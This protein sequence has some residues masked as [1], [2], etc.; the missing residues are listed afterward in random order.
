MARIPTS[1]PCMLLSYSPLPSSIRRAKYLLLSDTFSTAGGPSFLTGATAKIFPVSG[2]MSLMATLPPLVTTFS[3]PTQTCSFQ[4]EALQRGCWNG[5]TAR[6]V[7]S[8]LTSRGGGSG[9]F[10]FQEA[11]M[12]EHAMRNGPSLCAHLPTCVCQHPIPSRISLVPC[13]TG[14]GGNLVHKHLWQ[15]G[16]DKFL[17]ISHSMVCLSRRNGVMWWRQGLN[18]VSSTV[19][20]S[21]PVCV[22]WCYYKV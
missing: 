7:K 12:R 6:R 11:F 19:T 16:L 10:S 22:C 5:Q 21:R 4:S 13:C 18:A 2:A 14:F 1:A 3:L 17:I 9:P 15:G 8:A 20:A